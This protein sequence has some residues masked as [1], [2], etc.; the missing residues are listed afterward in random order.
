VPTERILK[1]IFVSG[2]KTNNLGIVKGPFFKFV[3]FSIFGDFN[4]KSH[5]VAWEEIGRIDKG[6]APALDCVVSEMD[7][8]LSCIING[9]G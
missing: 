8:G 7:D 6:A 9:Q 1:I 3:W 2:S 4:G 5:L